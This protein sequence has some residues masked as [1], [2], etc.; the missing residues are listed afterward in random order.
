M[1][2]LLLIVAVLVLGVAAPP[3]QTPETP[4]LIFALAVLGA[5]PRLL[6]D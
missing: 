4:L 5:A 3:S 1:S 6:K 2:Q